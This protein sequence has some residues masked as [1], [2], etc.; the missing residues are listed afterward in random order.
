MRSKPATMCVKRLDAD[1]PAARA[2]HLRAVLARMVCSGGAIGGGAAGHRKRLDR[3]IP[4]VRSGEQ[5]GKLGPGI[6][7]KKP[8]AEEAG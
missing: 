3:G 7:R 1:D 8:T 5:D 2:I 6:T 4:A